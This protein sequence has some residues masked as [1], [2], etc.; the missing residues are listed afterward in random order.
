V[1]GTAVPFVGSATMDVRSWED[2]ALDDQARFVHDLESLGLP[3]SVVQDGLE[4]R[5]AATEEVEADVRDFWK[6]HPVRYWET[7]PEVMR[8]AQLVYDLA[9][10]RALERVRNWLTGRVITVEAR[11]PVELSLPLFLLSAPSRAGCTATFTT[12]D[13]QS[14]TS[15]W[16]VRI[17]GVGI[18]NEGVGTVTASASF[19]AGAGQRKLI[20]LPIRIVVETLVVTQR[21]SPV[22]SHRIDLTGLRDRRPVPG[23]ILLDSEAKPR[24]GD[25][26]ETYPLAKDTSDSTATYV[27]RYVQESASTIRIGIP[28]QGVDVGITSSTKMK[29]A[30][31]ITFKLSSGVDYHLYRAAEG[32]GLLWG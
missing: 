2:V 24:T 7:P 11:Q 23:A 17:G 25:H 31:E 15:G 3:L 1:R 28:I 20:F 14:N 29:S 21:G 32:D 30:A 9:R 5:A 8:E 13:E 19:E 6:H 26:L 16:S 22:R 18:S 27:Y 10:R 4:I 12:S